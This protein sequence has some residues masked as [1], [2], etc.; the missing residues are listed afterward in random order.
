MVSWF[1]SLNMLQGLPPGQEPAMR[2]G[3]GIPGQA[4]EVLKHPV[5]SEQAGDL[6]PAESENHRVRQRR[7]QLAGTVA[8]VSLSRSNL[9]GRRVFE[10]DPRYESMK[11][12]R[13]PCNVSEWR[14][15]T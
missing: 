6:D 7:H 2:G 10:A 13:R 14:R 12:D 1:Q 11:E 8:V 15:Q 5:P 9:S 4:G 3:I